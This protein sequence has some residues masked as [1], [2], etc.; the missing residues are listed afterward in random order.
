M[1]FCEMTEGEREWRSMRRG[2]QTP[3]GAPPMRKVREVR[4][5]RQ[6]KKGLRATRALRGESGECT[7]RSAYK[8]QLRSGFNAPCDFTTS[9]R[10]TTFQLW[11][12]DE[13]GM[14]TLPDGLVRPQVQIQPPVMPWC[15]D[16]HRPAPVLPHARGCS[17]PPWGTPGTCPDSLTIRPRRRWNHRG[18]GRAPPQQSSASL[19]R[20]HFLKFSMC[21]SWHRSAEGPL[22]FLHLYLWTILYGPTFRM[23]VQSTKD[24]H[25]SKR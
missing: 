9:S 7:A 5:T 21:V 22:P 6:K 12:R 3:S 25:S 8:P 13:T 16:G 11:A 24:Q 23:C 2:P 20:P 17:F 15:Q 18:K 10:R 19:P 4:R 14:A 1:G